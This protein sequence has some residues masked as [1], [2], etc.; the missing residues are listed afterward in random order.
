MG[1]GEGLRCGLMKQGGDEHLLARRRRSGSSAE[2]GTCPCP[3]PQ[4]RPREIKTISWDAWQCM[5]H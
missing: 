3:A 2:K 1:E 5:M 4:L